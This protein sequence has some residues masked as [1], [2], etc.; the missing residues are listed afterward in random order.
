MSITKRSLIIS[1]NLL[2]WISIIVLFFV[3]YLDKKSEPTPQVISTAR[4]QNIQPKPDFSPSLWMCKSV[5]ADKP[6]FVYFVTIDLE[7]AL[8]GDKGR[9][10]QN[11]AWE[12]HVTDNGVYLTTIV[13]TENASNTWFLYKKDDNTLRIEVPFKANDTLHLDCI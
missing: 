3:F 12:R 10:I 2:L 4:A 9:Y 6:F 11:G 13:T 8:F 1:G 5:N 7:Y